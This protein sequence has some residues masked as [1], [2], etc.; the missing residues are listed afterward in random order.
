MGRRLRS[1]LAAA[2]VL[3][4]TGMLMAQTAI[5]SITTTTTDLANTQTNGTTFDNTTQAISTFTDSNSTTYTVDGSVNI[6][7]ETAY[8]RRE[9]GSTNPN[10]TSIWYAEDTT[11]A[12]HFRA[13]YTATA[14]SALLG[15]NILRGAD[16]VF[17]NGTTT[18]DGNIERLDFIFSSSGITAANTMAFAVFE[19][20]A[21]SQHDSFE[22]AVITSYNSSTGLVTYGG[23]LVS[24]SA[25]NYG[26]TN[27][28]ANFTYNLFRY[29]NGDNLG[30]PSFWSDDASTGTQGL[31]G[32][33]LTLSNFGLAAGTTIYGYSLMASDVT[34]GGNV[35][36][37]AD[38]T[39]TTYYPTNSSDATGGAGGL[40]PAAVNGVLFRIVPEPSA[41]GAVFA[42]MATLMTLVRRKRSRVTSPAA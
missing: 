26:S 15:N 20:G 28:V 29:S 1:R 8:V 23:N 11:T 36:N 10:Q 18:S 32:V 7:N 24:V 34:D 35:N 37:L 21:A 39:N 9:T 5:T 6:S 3:A 41:Y 13:P 22:I 17:A 42:G 2:W 25:A 27:P 30:G 14:S 19:R 4:A 31:G 33:V 12:T 38:W 40:D 16:N